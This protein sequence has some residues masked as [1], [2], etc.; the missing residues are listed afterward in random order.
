MNYFM[1]KN[2]RKWATKPNIYSMNISH[3]G[4][5]KVKKHMETEQTSKC[6]LN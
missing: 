5:W 4:F 3:N 2:R 1:E 6:Q